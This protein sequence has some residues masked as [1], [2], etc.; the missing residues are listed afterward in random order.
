YG[1]NEIPYNSLKNKRKL[2]CGGFGIVYQA[3]LI[4]LG[5][6]AIKEVESETDEKAQK[7]FINE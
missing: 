2:G 7:L 6:V 1:L 4:S 3:E 5:H